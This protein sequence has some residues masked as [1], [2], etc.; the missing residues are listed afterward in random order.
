M[1]IYCSINRIFLNK[2]ETRIRR[3]PS[4]IS[5]HTK[6]DDAFIKRDWVNNEVQNVA[7]V[8]LL[9]ILF[10]HVSFSLFCV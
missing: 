9:F 5:M 8:C 6:R 2:Y 1:D 10:A 7:T 3:R 4:L